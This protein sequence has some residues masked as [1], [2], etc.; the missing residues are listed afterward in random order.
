MY[1]REHA[2]YRQWIREFCHEKGWRSGVLKFFPV[3][4]PLAPAAFSCCLPCQLIGTLS[5][6]PQLGPG[7][8]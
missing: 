8:I 3:V 1:K 6:L 7:D 4:D 2:F 5:E